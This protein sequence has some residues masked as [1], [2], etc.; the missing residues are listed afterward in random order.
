MRFHST[1]F[2]QMKQGC[3]TFAPT[4]V[5]SS[6]KTLGSTASTLDEWLAENQG[7]SQASW[8]LS[9]KLLNT[10]YWETRFCWKPDS[11]IPFRRIIRFVTVWGSQSSKCCLAVNSPVFVD[12]TTPNNVLPSSCKTFKHGGNR[13]LHCSISSVAAKLEKL[14]K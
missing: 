6:W 7:P 9:Y 14:S 8:G 2:N 5:L 13:R 12:R 4:P 11:S 10:C 3:P 1:D